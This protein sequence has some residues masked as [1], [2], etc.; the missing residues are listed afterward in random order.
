MTHR[1]YRYDE[2]QECEAAERDPKARHVEAFVQY[3]A[4]DE[5]AHETNGAWRTLTVAQ[6]PKAYKYQEGEWLPRVQRG[7]FGLGRLYP[8]HPT[9]GDVYYL[10]VLLCHLKGADV[11][12]LVEEHGLPTDLSGVHLLKQPHDTFK[13]ACYARGLLADDGEWFRAMSEANEIASPS[14]LRTLYLQILCYCEPQSP[15][16]LFDAFYLDMGDDIRRELERR[17]LYTDGNVRSCV[18]WMLHNALD[19]ANSSTEQCAAEQLHPLS[20]ED[21]AFVRSLQYIPEQTSLSHAYDYER[22]QQQCIYDG[23]YERCTEVPAQKQLVDDVRMH[24]ANDEQFFL[25]VDGPGGCGKT[26]T[27]NCIL[28]YIRAQGKVALA[29]ATTGIAALQLDGGR[30]VHTAFR[31]PIDTT[32]TRTG[33]FSLNI[34]RGTLLGKLIVHD[35]SVIVWDEAPYGS[36]RYSREFGLQ[37]SRVAWRHSSVWRHKRRARRRLSAMSAC[38]AARRTRRNGGSVHTSLPCFCRQLPAR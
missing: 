18:L 23:R 26:Y 35:L 2:G 1:L 4:S 13:D 36:S 25:Y 29:V 12:D 32:G 16:E 24:L 37:H 7:I 34:D 3:C 28:A 22:M 8:V 10:R 27:F 15:Y 19:V 20:A 38:R 6:F 21:E 31:V 5:R 33:P 9:K 14:Q 11:R 30:T 17:R